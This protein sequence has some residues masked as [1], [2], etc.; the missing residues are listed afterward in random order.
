MDTE[1]TNQSVG[2]YLKQAREAANLSCAQVAESLR[3]RVSVVQAIEADKLDIGVPMIFI[4]GY[5]KNYARLLHLPETS[6]APFLEEL[7]EDDSEA[8]EVLLADSS[9]AVSYFNWQRW[10]ALTVLV[11]GGLLLLIYFR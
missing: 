1:E 3:L 4:R 7:Q 10:L 5:I 11:L 9:V 8:E 2:N 6:I